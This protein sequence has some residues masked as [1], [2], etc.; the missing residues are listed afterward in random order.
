MVSRHLKGAV[1]VGDM[2]SA[3]LRHTG[4]SLAVCVAAASVLVPAAAGSQ[5]PASAPAVSLD[6]LIAFNTMCVKCHEGECS[7]RLSF[8]SG[9]GA[10][11][12]HIRRYLGELTEAQIRELFIVLRHMKE[13]CAYYPFPWLVPAD[14]R[15]RA[16][17]LA[18][19][20]SPAANGYFIPLGALR[21]QPYRLR[22]RLDRDVPVQLRVT[23]ATFEPVL[24]AVVCTADTRAMVTV[25][26][27][28]AAEHFLHLG[29]PRTARLLELEL[30]Q[31]RREPGSGGR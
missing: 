1:L 23:S 21:D 13:R 8:D 18:R 5:P 29:V 31:L 2:I 30:E 22:L 10:A 4:R 19:L 28:E 15:W 9:A 17:S 6:S 20:R 26:P 11:A 25:E 16:E 7:G 27:A 24:D 3:R 12:G 14:R